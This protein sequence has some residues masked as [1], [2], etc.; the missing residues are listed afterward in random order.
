[1]TVVDME[2]HR[3]AKE[4][5]DMVVAFDKAVDAMPKKKRER[6][7][8][9]YAE[10][11]SE[12]GVWESARTVMKEIVVE[13]LTD[14]Q[15]LVLRVA[16]DNDGYVV[17]GYNVTR[18]GTQFRVASAALDAATRKG[19]FDHRFGTEGEMAGILTSFGREVAEEAL[20]EENER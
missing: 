8:A 11:R 10:L 7:K 5:R 14:A 15:R 13:N 2:A 16:V 18:K 17:A 12:G 20:K 4:I 19:L 6:W 9:R 3:R 1:M